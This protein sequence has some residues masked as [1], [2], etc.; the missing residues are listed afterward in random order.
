MGPEVPPPS[1]PTSASEPGSPPGLIASCWGGLSR[2]PKIAAPCPVSCRRQ[3]QLVIQRFRKRLH[4]RKW[5]WGFYGNRGVKIVWEHW[6]AA[7]PG[8]D[9]SWHAVLCAAGLVAGPRAVPPREL[10]PGHGVPLLHPPAPGELLAPRGCAGAGMCPWCRVEPG[11]L[12]AVTPLC[13]LHVPAAAGCS[14]LGVSIPAP[15]RPEQG[16]ALGLCKALLVPCPPGGGQ[17]VGRGGTCG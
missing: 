9:S 15:S 3:E 2:S 10:L 14:L 1:V 16:A 17:P 6:G 11:L 8:R 13:P 4:H 7:R 12:P 5:V